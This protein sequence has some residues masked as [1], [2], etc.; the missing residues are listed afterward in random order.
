[1]NALYFITGNKDK[2]REALVV[3]PKLKRLEIDLPEIQS[4]D[5]QKI[6]EYKLNEAHKLHSDK[7][8]LVEDISLNLDNL[9]GLPGPL[10]KWFLVSIGCEG[11]FDLV[12]GKNNKATAKCMIGLQIDHTQKFF[13]SEI[14]GTIV[15]PRGTNGFGWDNIFVPDGQKRT[16]A[17]MTLAEKQEYSVRAFSYQ[18]VKK[19]LAKV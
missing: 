8:F 2:Y 10:I 19:F 11:I 15:S 7:N 4:L 16:L 12:K 18:K 17:E 5:P 9:K 1:M 14:K 6:I 13:E 3:L